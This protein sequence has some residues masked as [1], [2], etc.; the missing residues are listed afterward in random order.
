MYYFSNPIINKYQSGRIIL[1]INIVSKPNNIKPPPAVV[2]KRKSEAERESREEGEATQMGQVR[3]SVIVL[4]SSSFNGDHHSNL[5]LYHYT[6]QSK[7]EAIHPYPRPDLGNILVTLIMK[8]KRIWLNWAN[9]A[10]LLAIPMANAYTFLLSDHYT[11]LSA[12]RG[13]RSRNPVPTFRLIR[14]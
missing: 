11:K 8:E 4:V 5:Q 6:I 13:V 14:S 9:M 2:E 7:T 10:S 3:F 12:A 1:T